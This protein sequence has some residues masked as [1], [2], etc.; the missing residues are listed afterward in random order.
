[1]E[2]DPLA[3]VREFLDSLPPDL[4]AEAMEQ[5]RREQ[6]S[7]RAEIAQ[8]LNPNPQVNDLGL[9]IA[10]LEGEAREEAIL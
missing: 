7:A 5:H 6:E 10:S 1:L 2:D 9:L 4:R 8:L 3:G